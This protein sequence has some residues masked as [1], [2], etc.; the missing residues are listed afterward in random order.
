MN[1]ASHLTYTNRIDLLKHM[2][3]QQELWWVPIYFKNTR[4]VTIFEATAI[5]IN[6]QTSLSI[7]QNTIKNK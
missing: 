7:A 1:P 2:K 3:N 5:S 4:V 6:Q